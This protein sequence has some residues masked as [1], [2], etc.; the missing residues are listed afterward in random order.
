MFG[1]FSKKSGPA[2]L[3][4]DAYQQGVQYMEHGDPERARLW[5]CRAD[6]IYSAD[7]SVYEAV[8][9]TLT[10]DCSERIGALEEADCFTNRAIA[11]VEEWAEELDGTQVRLWGLMTMARL[12]PLG[13]RLSA[14]AGCGV[15][16]RLERAVSLV[17]QSFRAPISG[18][19]FGELE[20]IRDQ[21]YEL[22]DSPR[23][24]GG[25]EIKVPGKAPF[26][27]FDLNGLLTVLGLNSYLDS[28]LACLVGEE[29]GAPG[30][31]TDL[32]PCAL[33]PD[34]YL[35]TQPGD[36]AQLPGVRA[37]LERIRD[38]FQFLRSGP[39]LSAAADRINGYLKLDILA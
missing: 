33:L 28:H 14:L 32:I 19:E 38:D 16:G 12:A 11:Q 20:E 17:L 25:G 7:D 6:T 10:D 35:R 1:F 24:W 39:D 2:Q 30:P 18:Q 13:T 31:Q 21:L 34:Y 22:S 26:Q 8:G 37:E 3:V 29:E 15:L 36:A 9:E 4:R 23:Y 27:V 5:L